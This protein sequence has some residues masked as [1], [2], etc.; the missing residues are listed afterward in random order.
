MCH[1]FAVGIATDPLSQGS[2]GWNEPAQA[3][4]DQVGVE[5]ELLENAHERQEQH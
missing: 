1:I 3:F 4:A 2:D 5:I